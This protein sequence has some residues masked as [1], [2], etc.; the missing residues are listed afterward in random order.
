MTIT[1]RELSQ[2]VEILYQEYIK[3]HPE[4]AHENKYPVLCGIMSAQAAQMIQ[5]AAH[6]KVEDTDFLEIIKNTIW[7][8][9]D[10]L[11]SQIKGSLQLTPFQYKTLLRQMVEGWMGNEIEDWSSVDLSELS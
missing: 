3:T 7:I 8:Y 10:S 6:V 5:E 1:S 11:A 9:A 2:Q 4:M